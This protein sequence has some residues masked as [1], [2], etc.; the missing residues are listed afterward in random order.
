M[1][2]PCLKK[3]ILRIFLIVLVLT[4]TLE[5]PLQAFAT[6][7]DLE[8]EEADATIT[9]RFG[10]CQVTPV[11]IEEEKYPIS[12]DVYSDELGTVILTIVADNALLMECVSVQ[13]DVYAP[14]EKEPL[15][16]SDLAIGEEVA[17]IRDVIPETQYQINATFTNELT[18]T[19]LYGCFCVVSKDDDLGVEYSLTEE[20]YKISECSDVVARELQIATELLAGDADVA[21]YA[22]GGEVDPL[23]SAAE[24]LL[25]AAANAKIMYEKNR[26]IPCE[27]PL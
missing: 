18:T 26:T 4:L 23:K 19:V 27:P 12:F 7:P 24:N 15:L 20:E 5:Y 22:D 10:D 9:S 17:E 25:T 11:E 21:M 8:R 16:S 14:E 3:Y 13:V 6:T 2:L 1:K